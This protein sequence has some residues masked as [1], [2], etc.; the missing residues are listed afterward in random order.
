MTAKERSFRE[1]MQGDKRFQIPFFQR[2]Y[3]WDE[4]NWEELLDNLLSDGHGHFLGSVILRPTKHSLDGVIWTVIDGQQRLT[5]L[6]VLFKVC[7]EIICARELKPE[8][9]AYYDNPLTDI[10]YVVTKSGKDLKLRHSRADAGAFNKIM[11]KPAAEIMSC[12]I[13]KCYEFFTKWF[14]GDKVSGTEKAERI[15]ETLSGSEKLLV[16]IEL[17]EEENEQIIFDTINSAG[18]RLTSADTIKNYL[19]QR[20]MSLGLGDSAVKELYDETWDYAF[21]KTA[22]A[23][24]YWLIE[25]RQGRI[26]RTAQENMLQC[27]AVV[28]GIYDPNKHSVVDLVKCFKEYVE[29]LNSGSLCELIRE[30]TQYALLYRKFFRTLDATTSYRFDDVCLRTLHIL[31]L[32]DTT[33]F[34]P[35][36]LHLISLDPPKDDGTISEDL[37]TR[38]NEIASFVLR[39]V[40]CHASVKNFNKDC[41]VIIHGGKTLLEYRDEKI[42]AL[43]IDDN[44]VRRHLL[45]MYSNKIATGILFW[46]ELKRRTEGPHELKEEQYTKTLE[47]LMPQAWEENW[48]VG[49]PC[50]VEPETGEQVLDNDRATELRKAAI[51]E[52]GNMALLSKSLNSSIKND[53]MK[54][55][56]EGDGGKHNGIKEY[57]TMLY[58]KDVIKKMIAT[59][60]VWN[61]ETIRKRTIEITDAFLEI[62]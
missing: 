4:E 24:E 61:E 37:V 56:I 21:A 7:H 2:Q 58:T 9:R 16:A 50:V 6:S 57:A 27:F 44:S 3:V 46:L 10:L 15:F 54:T 39:H 11:L 38:L 23:N 29:N 62:W 20:L 12:Q 18:V 25:K 13:V 19:F 36:I 59:D 22:E 45:E 43:N 42:K 14:I 1:I 17:D 49:H 32:C 28:K 33:T 40:V 31:R 60:Y 30:L 35:L 26:T 52:I 51:Y 41:A 47:H 48:K 8:E 34:D 55:K 5:T 53:T